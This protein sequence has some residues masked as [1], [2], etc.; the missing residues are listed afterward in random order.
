MFVRTRARNNGKQGNVQG[1]RARVE[2]DCTFLLV[3]TGTEQKSL[4]FV[5]GSIYQTADHAANFHILA[6]ATHVENRNDVEQ[7][8]YCSA[9][10]TCLKYL[11][12]SPLDAL[13]QYWKEGKPRSSYMHCDSV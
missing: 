5:H 4:E 7:G 12:N 11:N 6:N 2:V 10:Q 1:W 9:S 8:K 3:A 13:R